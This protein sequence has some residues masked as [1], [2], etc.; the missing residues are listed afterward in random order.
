MSLESQ[1][2]YLETRL[3][4]VA[5]LY[6]PTPALWFDNLAF[7]PNI[8]GNHIV[9]TI[10]DG[11]SRPADI[12]NKTVDRHVGIVQIDVLIPEDSGSAPA[13]KMA[14]YFGNAFRKIDVILE[15]GA[16]LVT[17]IP[18]YKNMGTKNSFYR[19]VISI[20]FKRDEKRA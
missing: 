9:L 17:K 11:D 5:P 15:D 10:L 7:E 20:P 4:N 3:T 16:R 2:S 6:T 8:S 13:K 19:Y 18:E 14:D 12:G 1:R